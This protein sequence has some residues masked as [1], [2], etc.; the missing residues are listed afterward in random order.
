MDRLPDLA[1]ITTK[2]RLEINAESTL[3]KAVSR[4]NAL[5][6]KVTNGPD[7]EADL[8]CPCD[9]SCQLQV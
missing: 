9:A 6:Y 1:D 2:S 5:D 7:A 4:D 3:R 8:T